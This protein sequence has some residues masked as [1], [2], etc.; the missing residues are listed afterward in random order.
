MR[1]AR[2]W[3]KPCNVLGQKLYKASLKPPGKQKF[4]PASCTRIRF[5]SSTAGSAPHHVRTAAGARF[6][7]SSRSCE[8]RLCTQACADRSRSASCE[9]ALPKV[10][11]RLGSKAC[12]TSEAVGLHP[13]KRALAA[14]CVGV[15]GDQPAVAL[16]GA[17]SQK[18]AQSGE[19]YLI[20]DKDEL[21]IVQVEHNGPVLW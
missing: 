11:G 5:A 18:F 4:R 1:E 3:S 6:E 2:P 14:I 17:L 10:D 21:Q 12:L 20:T 8:G 7:E 19:N 16:R 13:R 15:C 9:H